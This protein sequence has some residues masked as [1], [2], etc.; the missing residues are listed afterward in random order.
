MPS[1]AAAGVPASTPLV[2]LKVM[3]LGRAPLSLRDGAG[4]PVAC[5]TKLPLLPTV[6][7][8]PAALEMA[9]AWLTVRCNVAV[10]S[11]PVPARTPL[12]GLT[13]MPLGRAPLS[14]R[15]GA[16]KPVA[17]TTKLPLLPTVKVVPAA[18]E[19]AGAWLTVK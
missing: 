10:V 12:V 9:G 4:K 18:L 16:G 17:C 1:L 8:V 14:L 2:G 19:M 11:E 6:K 5:T 13:V 15:D 3:P 7:V